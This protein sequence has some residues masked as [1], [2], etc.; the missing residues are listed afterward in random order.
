[1][2]F[3]SI[4]SFLSISSTGPLTLPCTSERYEDFIAFGLE[5]VIG[6]VTLVFLSLLLLK[7]LPSMKN[8]SNDNASVLVTA[9]SNLGI[10]KQVTV[11]LNR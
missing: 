2:L 1:M 9:D 3:C 5:M 6:T 4:H 7:W 10:S 8:Q 11:L